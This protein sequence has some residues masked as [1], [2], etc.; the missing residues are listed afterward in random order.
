[1]YADG[2][3]VTTT[4]NWGEGFAA[5]VHCAIAALLLTG[6]LDLSK[7]LRHRPNGWSNWWHRLVS[8][9]QVTAVQ[10]RYMRCTTPDHIGGLEAWPRPPGR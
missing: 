8:T 3:P 2:R 1:M 10:F 5:L 7:A 4:I 9:V 6:L